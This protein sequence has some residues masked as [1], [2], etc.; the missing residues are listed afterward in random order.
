IK[1]AED[2]MYRHKLIEKQ[3]SHNSIISSLEKALEE[4]NYE[5]HEHMDRMKVLA[6]ELGK[7][8]QF[9]ED[10]LDELSL[11]S[12]LHVIGKI[13]ISDNIILN[14]SKLTN[15]EFEIMKKHTE[16]GFRIANSNSELASIAKG[17][18]AHHERWDGK[19]YPMGLESESIPIIARA[20]SII[21]SY[22]AM[23]NDRPYRKAHSKEYAIK[24]LLKY[25]GSQF[26][27]VLVEQFISMI[28][29]EKVLIK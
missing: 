2:N 9:S 6:L 27:P 18:L 19:G 11:L 20:I 7:K 16:V 28:T 25:A 26:D 21:D 24:E 3:S 13:A 22:D 5:T 29:N 14:P 17:I 23:I 15:E 12:S 10:K 1:I 4:R 8:L